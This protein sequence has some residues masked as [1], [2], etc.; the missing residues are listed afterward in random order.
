MSYTQ[1]AGYISK[2][3]NAY[4]KI[5]N[6]Q[7]APRIILEKSKKYQ[8]RPYLYNQGPDDLTPRERVKAYKAPAS[9]LQL[10][11]RDYF[12]A[13]RKQGLTAEKIGHFW[14]TRNNEFL[15][16]KIKN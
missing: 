1:Y 10:E 3:G 16:H 4:R 6:Y 13:G 2:K 8:K 14:R 9:A 11:Y 12:K 7:G 5:A 15:G